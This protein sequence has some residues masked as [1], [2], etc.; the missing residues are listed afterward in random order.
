MSRRVTSSV[1]WGDWHGDRVILP[2]CVRSPNVNGRNFTRMLDAMAGRVRHVELVL[3]D[4]LDRHNL[5]GDGDLAMRQSR[6]WQAAHL[7]EA[8]ARFSSV[9]VIGWQEIMRDSSFGRRH[10]AIHDLYANNAAVKK[11][12]DINVDIYVRDKVWRIIDEQ[13]W[14][15]NPDPREIELHSRL[16]LLEEY[17]GT[18]IYKDLVPSKTQ[19]YWGVYIEDTHVFRRHSGDVDLQLPRTLPVMNNRLGAS[20]R[21][22]AQPAEPMRAWG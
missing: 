1:V 2:I 3:C 8:T 14:E 21:S 10:R 15:S 20:V 9:N 16:Y 6:E 13:G 19:I 18:A 5:D 17:A 7:K 22:I 11:A 12:I 4:Y